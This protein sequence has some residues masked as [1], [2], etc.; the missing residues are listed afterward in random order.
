MKLR[1]GFIVSPFSQRFSIAAAPCIDGLSRTF[2]AVRRDKYRGE[3]RP[4]AQRH[5]MNCPGFMLQR[6]DRASIHPRYI[7][8]RSDRIKN[9]QKTYRIA[10]TEYV[11]FANSY[12]IAATGHEFNQIHTVS[13]RQSRCVPGTP[14]VSQRQAMNS[15]EFIPYLGDRACVFIVGLKIHGEAAV[16]SNNIWRNK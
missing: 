15:T 10:A 8:W 6:S 11:F 1:S 7:S 4:V 3:T 12:R 5:G 2:P 14:T 13:Q 9:S 16:K